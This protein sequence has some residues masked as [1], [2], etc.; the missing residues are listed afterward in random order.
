MLWELVKRG[1]C[2]PCE[3]AA[4]HEMELCRYTAHVKS[5]RA[6]AMQQANSSS[7]ASGGQPTLPKGGQG[8]HPSYDAGHPAPKAEV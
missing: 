3:G 8:V 1:F 4:L 2:A 5:Q 7:L 6:A